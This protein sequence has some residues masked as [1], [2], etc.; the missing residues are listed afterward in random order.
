MT[1]CG[2]DLS[3]CATFGLVVTAIIFV[4]F[5]AVLI[6]GITIVATPYDFENLPYFADTKCT[7]IAV[8]VVTMPNCDTTAT[9]S[10]TIYYDQYVAI[11][12]CKETGASILENPFAGNRQESIA[13]NSIGDFP[14][15]I[16]QNVSCNTVNLPVQYPGWKNFWGCQVW[17][18]CFFDTDMIKDL[19]ANAQTR[20]NRGFHLLYA[21]AGLAGL[22]VICFIV[23]MVILCDCCSCGKRSEYV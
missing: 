1:C 9:E 7:P 5:F 6:A 12:Q 15:K 18:T 20:Y 3:N 23:S 21:S 13:R 22:S 8:T 14:L 2:R 10:G 11:W 17:N 19:Q 16:T 4:T